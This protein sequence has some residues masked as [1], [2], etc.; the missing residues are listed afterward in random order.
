MTRFGPVGLEPSSYWF[1]ALGNAQHG[2]GL[3]PGDIAEL[4]PQ[5]L[6]ECWEFMEELAGA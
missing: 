2:P 1:P 4:S 6:N 3:R 5:Q